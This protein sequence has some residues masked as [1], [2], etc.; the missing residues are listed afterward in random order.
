MKST[1]R[2]SFKENG[3]YHI[4]LDST[5]ILIQVDAPQPSMLSGF[6]YFELLASNT[7]KGVR[8]YSLGYTMRENLRGRI[9]QE[10]GTEDFPLYIGWHFVSQEL[11]DLI[12]RAADEHPNT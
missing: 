8:R 9:I 4:K 10:I 12:R 6:L 2:M 11:T 5:E 7:T 3:I 1:P